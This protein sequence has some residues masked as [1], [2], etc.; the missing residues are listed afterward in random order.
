MSES[1]RGALEIAY[2]KLTQSW[3]RGTSDV[4]AL[5]LQCRAMIDGLRKAGAAGCGW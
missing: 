3:M 4:Q 1:T 5:E 2:R